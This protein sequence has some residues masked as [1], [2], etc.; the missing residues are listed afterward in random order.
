MLVEFS[1][2]N[3]RSFREKQTFTMVASNARAEKEGPHYAV[4]TDNNAAPHVLREAC[5]FGANGSGKSALIDGMNAMC[6]F[7]KESF[8]DD[9][10]T[11]KLSPHLFHSEWANEPTEFEAVFL[12]GGSLYQYGFA[13]DADRIHEEWLFERPNS[14][15]R[16]RQIFT[17]AYD[18]KTKS[19]SWET[20][21]SH[22]KGERESWKAQTRDNALFLSTAIALNAESLEEPHNW[23]AMGLQTISDVSNL[24]PYTAGRFD[25]EG[26]KE[27]VL[28]FLQGADILFADIE[29]NEQSPFDHEEFLRLPAESKKHVKQ[30]LPEN[31]KMLSIQTYRKNEQAQLVSL[32]IK[33]ESSG[34]Q[35]L[36]DLAGPI[37]DA[38]EHGLTLVVDELNTRLH[39]LAFRY[40]TEQFCDP[41]TNPHNAQLI[42]STH[43]LS[44]ADQDCMAK[45]QIWLVEKGDDLASV[46]KP[47]SEFKT[48][49][50]RPFRKGYLQGRYGAVPRLAG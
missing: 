16:L 25:E 8:K 45:D 1:L 47:F 10:A 34:T 28:E 7:V 22:L 3:H 4:E 29:V 50:T 13:V 31:A 38:L 15:G 46:L 43:D 19:Y 21:T 12:H 23:L 11:Q 9:N 24:A 41:K 39:P 32:A 17:R 27:R 35:S 37:L 49:D 2:Q 14:T 6:R 48:R 36:F 26:W 18:T 30:I 40:I 20:S 5:L 33:E 44:V 42:F